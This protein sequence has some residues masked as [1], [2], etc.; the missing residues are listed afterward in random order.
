MITSLMP[1]APHDVQSWTATY[2]EGSIGG[3]ALGVDPAPNV[4]PPNAARTFRWTTNAGYRT[5]S[6]GSL[7]YVAI[8]GTNITLQPWL[9]DDVKGI[10]LQFGVAAG[11]VITP[12]AVGTLSLGDVAGVKVFTRIMANTGCE[13]FATI[14]R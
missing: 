1:A 4:T 11:T 5:R 12:P 8:N 3:G 13:M 7:S 9:F 14:V 6:G 2:W 10:W